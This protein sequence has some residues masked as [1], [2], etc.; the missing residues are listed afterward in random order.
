MLASMDGAEDRVPRKPMSKCFPMGGILL[1]GVSEADV[2]PSLH[3]IRGTLH[4]R[5]AMDVSIAE[6]GVA[7]AEGLTASTV[8]GG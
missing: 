3:V 8:R 7:K 4:G 1:V 5:S 2:D 6:G